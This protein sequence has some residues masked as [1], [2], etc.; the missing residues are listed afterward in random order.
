MLE[1]S[2]GSP[3]YACPE[4]IRVRLEK[5][6]TF[7]ETTIKVDIIYISIQSALVYGRLD[8]TRPW[9]LCLQDRTIAS[10]VLAT[11]TRKQEKRRRRMKELEKFIVIIS[12]IP[13]Q[14]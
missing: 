7:C 9:L 14:K 10:F 1:T 2:C 8:T 12:N 13:Q 6:H 11:E 5:Q 4:V 3:H